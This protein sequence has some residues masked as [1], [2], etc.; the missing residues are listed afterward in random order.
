MSTNAVR[1]AERRSERLTE[2]LLTAQAWDLRRP[3][4][5]DVLTQQEYKDFPS[6]QEA[7]SKSSKSGP[8]AGIPEFIVAD[9]K[10]VEPLMVF[11]T[12]ARST[13][14]EQ[15]VQDVTRYGDAFTDVSFHP[16]AVA[17]AGT[18]DE[19]FDIRVLKKRAKGWQSITYEGNPITWIPNRDQLERVLNTP[20][21]MD[22]R[23]TVPPLEVLKVRADEINR[24]LRESG[25]KDDFRPGAIGAIMLALWKSRGDIRRDHHHILHDINQS[26]EQAFWDAGKAKLANSL[27]VNEANEKLAIRS[28]RICEI[29]ERLNITTLTAEHDYIG[30][31]YEEFFRYTGGNTI[32]QYFTPR[33]ITA[34]MAELCDVDENDKVIDIACGTGGFLIAAMHIMQRKAHLTHEEVVK[35]VKTQLVGLEDEPVTAALCVAN[36]ILRGDGSTGIKEVDAFDDSSFPFL[37]ANVGLMNPP[38]PHEKTDRPPEQFIDRLLDAVLRRGKAA[39]VV[40]SSFLVKKP[41]WRQDI[42]KKH[43]LLAVI[44]LPDELFQPYAATNTAILMFEKGVPQAATRHTFFC[45]V[46]NDGL[47]LKKGVRVQRSGS[48][49]PLVLQQ[50]QS[51]GTIAGF[52]KAARLQDD[53]WA[54]GSY[55]DAHPLSELEFRNEVAALIRGKVAFMSRFAPQLAKMLHAVEVGDLS[56]K[57]YARLLAKVSKASTAQSGKGTIGDCFHVLYGQKSLHSKEKLGEGCALVISSSGMDNGCYGFFDFPDLI[58]APFVTVPSTG[59]IGEAVVQEFPC[60]VTD[61]CLLLFP[62]EGTPFEALYVAAA[63]LR[64]ERWRFNYGRKMTPTRIANFPLRLDDALLKWVRERWNQADEVARQ[65]VATLAEE[66]KAG[67]DTEMEFNRLADEWEGER[68]RGVDVADMVMHNAYQRII[69]LGPRVVPLILA[70]LEKKPDHWFWALHAITG[71]EPV[72]NWWRQKRKNSPID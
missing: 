70:R 6:L 15:A 45:R 42:L 58:E 66:D 48:Q 16:I 63:T 24:L 32:G 44:S 12:K 31:L 33:H 9:R 72:P 2:E 50:Y 25:L 14:I 5:G 49:I 8:G 35:V 17:V 4:F 51:L 54:P 21:L 26:C 68:P 23:P 18:G 10:S 34:L 52:C 30:T 13:D 65:S 69:G 20:R 19:R 67:E 59:S 1:V 22:L 62:K 53:D 29:L 40:P 47:C 11:E 46:E 27:R 55:I 41:G 71:A 28:R 56:P 60:G 43:S 61:D 57:P 39:T 37:T 36:M 64:H 38:F 3:P 7:L